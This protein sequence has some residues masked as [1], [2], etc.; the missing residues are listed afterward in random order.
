VNETRATTPLPLHQHPGSRSARIPL[1]PPPGSRPAD[2]LEVFFVPATPDSAWNPPTYADVVRRLPP[3][4]TPPAAS[5]PRHPPSRQLRSTIIVPPGSTYHVVRP[6]HR[7]NARRDGPLRRTTASTP[8][9]PR[10]SPQRSPQPASWAELVPASANGDRRT[11]LKLERQILR[12][13]RIQLNL[14]RPDDSIHG[15]LHRPLPD[16]MQVR[17]REMPSSGRPRGGAS[18]ALPGTTAPA[19][20]ETP[21][22]VFSALLRPQ[23]KSLPPESSSATAVPSCFA[24]RQEWS[25]PPP[26]LPTRGGLTVPLH[27]NHR[28]AKPRCRARPRLRGPRWGTLCSDRLRITSTSPPPLRWNA[29]A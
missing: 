10:R 24:P 20:A 19:T 17:C 12:D 25:S 29:S 22:A 18:G 11:G 14:R 16:S 7:F 3:A 2:P 1:P 6:S 9:H 26:P 28:R 21:S 13:I 4:S 23:T 27:A 5:T 8:V 15:A